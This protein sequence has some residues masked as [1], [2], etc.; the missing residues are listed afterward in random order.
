MALFRDE[1]IA[2]KRMQ[3]RG[4]LLV[5]TPP[6]VRWI[7]IAGVVFLA[8]IVAVLFFADYTRRERVGGELASSD[9]GQNALSRV[10]GVVT[11]V[12]AREGQAVKSGQEIARIS[13]DVGGDGGIGA[14]AEVRRKLQQQHE[15]LRAE[16]DDKVQLQK[17]EQEALRQRARNISSRIAAFDREI[18]LQQ[19]LIASASARLE[20]FKPL[21]KE[22][23]VSGMQMEQQE[24]AVVQAKTSLSS[25]QRERLQSGQD[26]ATV[27]SQIR[28]YPQ[29][30]RND[31]S[32]VERTLIG[33]EQELAKNEAQREVVIRAARDGMVVNL[34]IADGVS[35]VAGQPLFQIVRP[36]SPLEARLF[37]ESRAVG[38]LQAG[39]RVVMRY[40]AFP[41][42][43]FGQQ[44]G[45]I[46][47]VSTKG[48]RAA[49]SAVF[50]D[51]PG[52]REKMAPLYQVV[53][54]LDDQSIAAGG[55]HLALRSGMQVEADLL[56][57]RRKIVSW[58]LD[59]LAGMQKRMTNGSEAR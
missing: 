33:L 8:A 22:G 6:S 53:V 56:I 47:S 32:E 21:V 36:G 13:L 59:P 24:A 4:A 23:Y 51:N 25:L 58:L 15:R 20:R 31:R 29:Q 16:I 39:Q 35:V 45:T 52:Q 26:L 37:V 10:S 7:A 19:S 30:S 2:A 54:A 48:L 9:E 28:Q 49:E 46:K 12:L 42:Q 41:Y 1:V 38:L 50:T 18:E 34:L 40:P 11:H 27:N 43:K 57:E 5:A 55:G 14:Y 17:G 3:Q 44:W